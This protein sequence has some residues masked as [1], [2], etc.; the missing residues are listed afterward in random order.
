MIVDKGSAISLMY[1]IFWERIKLNTD[2]II[3]S[4]GEVIGF[5]REKSN[6]SAKS[7]FI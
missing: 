6:L 7:Y 5:N 3:L 1:E 2:Y 4:L